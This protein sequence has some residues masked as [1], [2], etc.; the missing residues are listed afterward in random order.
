MNT[1]L[2]NNVQFIVG[3]TLIF[4][5]GCRTPVMMKKPPI[6][7]PSDDASIKLAEAAYSISN[8]M[9]QMARVEKVLMPPETDNIVNIPNSYNLQTRARIDWDGPIEDLLERIAHAAHYRMRVLGKSPPIP[10]LIN[11]NTK[12][13]SLAEILRDIDYQAGNKATIHV[14]PSNQVIELRYAKFYS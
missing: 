6:N 3:L 13:E 4:L 1:T 5:G 11:L 2:K 10:I 8:S 7:A 14:Y 12:D 9:M